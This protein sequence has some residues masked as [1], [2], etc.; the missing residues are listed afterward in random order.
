MNNYFTKEGKL[1]TSKYKKQKN[2][3]FNL[4]NYQ[5]NNTFSILSKNGEQEDY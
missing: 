1:I 3:I 5:R 4:S 2:T